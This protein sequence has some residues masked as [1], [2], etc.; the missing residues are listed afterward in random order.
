M[1][2][3]K[4][5]GNLIQLEDNFH[6]SL[7]DN[8]IVS[9]SGWLSEWLLGGEPQRI[10]RQIRRRRDNFVHQVE[11]NP[12]LKEEGVHS[13]TSGHTLNWIYDDVCTLNV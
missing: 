4:F 8:L 12:S 10:L 7:A 11:E 6:D 13:I 5:E 2:E 3:H 9:W 1:F